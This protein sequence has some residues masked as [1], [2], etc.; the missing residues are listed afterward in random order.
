MN[1]TRVEDDDVMAAARTKGVMNFS[2]IKYAILERNGAISI[3]KADQD[4]S[5]N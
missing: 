1:S 3:I 5:K 4:A 2:G